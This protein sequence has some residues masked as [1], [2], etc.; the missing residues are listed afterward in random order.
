MGAELIKMTRTA[1]SH[2]RITESWQNC[3]KELKRV[4]APLTD[5]QLALRPV[6]GQRSLGE[7]AEHL[8]RARA[9]WLERALG[10]R[11]LAA[12]ANWDEPEDPTRTAADIVQGLDQTWLVISECL[13]R[14][15]NDDLGEPVPEEEVESLQIVMGM[16]D[17]ELHHGGELSFVL[18][19]YKLETQDM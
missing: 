19:V 12:M 15:A 17:H 2:A 16:M 7:I 8:V 10:D 14:W 6:P 11:G 1:L 4:I 5:E 18:G 9:L 13:A 3:Q